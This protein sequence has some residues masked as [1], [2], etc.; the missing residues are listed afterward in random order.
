MTTVTGGA[1]SAFDGY[2][3]IESVLLKY[4]EPSRH[5]NYEFRRFGSKLIQPRG[6]GLNCRIPVFTNDTTSGV[7]SRRGAAIAPADAQEY[8]RGT[9]RALAH[10]GSEV[11]L[12]Y[13][14]DSFGISKVYADA[15]TLR[16]YLTRG[17]E[18]L[19]VGTALTEEEIIFDELFWNTWGTDLKAPANNFIMVEGDGSI[20]GT[21]GTL[22][23]E[24]I[25]P[26]ALI[27][28]RREL[29]KRNA[30]GIRQ[31]NNSYVG[32][33]SP[34]H[35]YSLQ[36]NL[37]G[38]GAQLSFEA[39]SMNMT[40]VYKNGRLGRFAGLELYETTHAPSFTG[41]ITNDPF[42]SGNS[43][44]YAVVLAAD[45]FYCATHET[46]NA[47]LHYSGFQVNAYTPAAEQATLAVDY[48]FAA[49]CQTANAERAAKIVVIPTAV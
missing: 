41:G 7:R 4:A 49:K 16:E 47:Q 8:T 13:Y 11:T 10:A 21:W 31:A 44:E 17:A 48:L 33:L 18:F 34:D 24:T 12:E 35:V 3:A 19:M 6:G 27:A 29:R 23:V 5:A 30:S 28:A 22:T 43:G 40:D 46:L 42:N 38:T 14:K 25:V 20:A 2:A 37:K 36:T 39:D 15:V 26:E 45:A 1:G 32:L 9:P